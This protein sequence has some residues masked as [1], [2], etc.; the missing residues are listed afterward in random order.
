[1]IQYN[2]EFIQ[3]KIISAFWTK[4][5]TYHTHTHAQSHIHT[6]DMNKGLLYLNL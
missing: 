6:E 4:F 3:Y 5:S 1:M 2:K